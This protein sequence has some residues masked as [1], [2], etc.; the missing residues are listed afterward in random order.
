MTC[1]RVIKNSRAVVTFHRF[2]NVMDP[3]CHGFNNSCTDIPQTQKD[4]LKL[5]R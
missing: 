1:D 3:F 2:G 4:K 5:S